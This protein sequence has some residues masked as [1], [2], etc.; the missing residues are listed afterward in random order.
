VVLQV[1]LSPPYGLDNCSTEHSH[2]VTTL[3]RVK[4]VVSLY[5]IL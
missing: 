5:A 2:N 3:E 4:K 1:E